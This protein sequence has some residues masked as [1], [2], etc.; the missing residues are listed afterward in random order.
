MKSK[1]EYILRQLMFNIV[2]NDLVCMIF[3]VGNNWM[4]FFVWV[5]G[6]ECLIM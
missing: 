6:L 5:S 1:E 2:W 3:Y 4:F